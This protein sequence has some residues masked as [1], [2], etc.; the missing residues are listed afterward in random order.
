MDLWTLLV[1][2]LFQS[3]WVTVI[4]ISFLMWGIFMLGRVSQVT[5]LNFL[6]FF[7]LSMS[8]GYGNSLISIGLTVIIFY[9]YLGALPRLINS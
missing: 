9:I 3:F 4:A 7:I 5:T 8:I 6:S 2:D 1:V